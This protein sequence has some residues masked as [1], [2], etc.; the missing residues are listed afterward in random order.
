VW[1]CV[2]R[3]GWDGERASAWR[4]LRELARSASDGSILNDDVGGRGPALPDQRWLL[5]TSISCGLTSGKSH[6]DRHDPPGLTNSSGRFGSDMSTSRR[7]GAWGVNGQR[8][9]PVVGQRFCPLVA[10]RTAR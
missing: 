6:L 2:C 5:I 7:S 3:L 4:V 8:A 10:N 1:D 9:L